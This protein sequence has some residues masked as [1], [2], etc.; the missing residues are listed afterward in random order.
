ML[1]V[2]I[3]GSLRRESSNASLL[4]AAARVAPQGVSIVAYDQ[5]A[6]LPHFNPDLDV[7]GMEPPPAVAELRRVLREADAVLLSSPE[8]AHGVPGA[9]K[10]L[11]DWLVSDGDLAGTPVALLNASPSGGQYAQA[12]IV[13]TLRTMSWDVV[14]E[15]CLLE[16]FVPNRI[17]G[18]VTADAVLSPLRTAVARLSAAAAIR[19]SGPAFTNH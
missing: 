2:A 12:A 17:V 19:R 14:R 9:F 7:D 8:Y 15:A 1:I 16:P 10:N 3:S 11:L 4:R 18:E 6:A 13:E 5:I